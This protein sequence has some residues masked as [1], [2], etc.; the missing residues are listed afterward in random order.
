MEFFFPPGN[1]I[2]Y[3][4]TPSQSLSS[5]CCVQKKKRGGGGGLG[6]VLNEIISHIG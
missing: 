2:S 5:W 6:H 1:W 3:Y 4:F